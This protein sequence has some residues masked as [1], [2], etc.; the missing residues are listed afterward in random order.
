MF[1]LVIII[2]MTLLSIFAPMFSKYSYTET[3]YA[4][5]NLGFSKEHWFGTDELGRDM[6]T[7]VWVGG[8]VSLLI[9]LLGAVLP[10][11]IG[12]IIG[13]ISG[14]FGGKVDMF[15]MRLVDIGMCIPNM[16]YIILLMLYLG[17]GPLSIIIAFSITAWMDTARSVRGLVLQLKEM[18]FVTAAKALGDSSLRI[19]FVHLI[20]N[21]IGFLI[22][23]IAGMIPG[24]IFAEAYMS[25]IGLGVQIPMTSWG[26]LCDAGTAVLRS[27]PHRL[28]I[29]AFL[30]SLTMLS[31]VLVGDGLRD[32]LDPKLRT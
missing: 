22:I 15:I 17:S 32:A 30:I 27:A 20:P 12:V 18:E 29:P 19:I 25:Y 6:W 7:R 2:I 21:I 14:Y 4:E 16:I 8:R 24:V 26:Q 5:A 10:C 23:R 28:F 13:G 31:F 1:G 9:G 11:I 3:N